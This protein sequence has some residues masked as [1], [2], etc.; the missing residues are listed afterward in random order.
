M[1]NPQAT[2]DRGYIA[3]L[4][5]GEGTISLNTQRYKHGSKFCLRPLVSITN[6]CYPIIEQMKE[7]FKRAEI[8]FWVGPGYK[9]KNPKEK[10][11]WTLV[12]NGHKRVDRLFTWLGEG[13]IGKREHIK[14]VKEYI[15]LRKDYGLVN[16]RNGRPIRT[17]REWEIFKELSVL[18]GNRG[19]KRQTKYFRA[20][21]KDYFRGAS[22]TTREAPAM[23]G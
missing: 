3:G 21:K 20:L 2:Y 1:D 13:N 12:I 16:G 10:T 5:D 9:N 22:E 14:L 6:T 23:A 4:I 11:Y 19:K 17:E 18:N 7:I 15:Q 8:A